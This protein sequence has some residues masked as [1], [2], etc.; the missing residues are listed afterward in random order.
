[1]FEVGM[2]VEVVRSI[3]PTEIG[4]WVNNWISPD[5]D[6]AVGRIGEI[7]EIDDSRD[8]LVKFGEKMGTSDNWWYP[9]FVLREVNS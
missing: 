8:I 7:L 3:S 4:F 6:K 1:M 5:M 9:Y 2:R